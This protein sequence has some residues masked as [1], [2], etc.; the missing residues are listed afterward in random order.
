[1][2]PA[3]VRPDSAIPAS[4]PQGDAYLRQTEATLPSVTYRD[5]FTDPRLQALIEQAL[6]NNRDLMIAAANVAAAREQYRIQRAQQLP[7]VDAVASAS[8]D[9][10]GT[11]DDNRFQAVGGETW[12]DGSETTQELRSALTS[13]MN[14]WSPARTLW[15]SVRP[16]GLR[17]ARICVS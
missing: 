5:I 6:V 4:W 14:N 10:G 8:A 2:Q 1:M 9:A 17:R 16:V 11:N 13:S 7:R 3:Y 15:P 12:E